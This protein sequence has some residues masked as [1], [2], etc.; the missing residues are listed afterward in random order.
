[1]HEGFLSD[2]IENPD[3]DTPRLVF[4][5]WL[6]ENGDPER[7]GFIRVQVELEKLP[8]GDPRRE[9]LERDER[10]LLQGHGTAWVRGI[11]PMLLREEAV[12][13][14][15]RGRPMW[16]FHRGFIEEVALD[17]DTFP[18]HAQALFARWPVRDAWMPYTN[19]A[20]HATL[21]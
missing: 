6:E 20:N 1:M 4:A 10:D 9:L 21:A 17:A 3:D 11:L 8:E 5:D 16:R 15:D 13:V 7:A 18:A 2:I 14:H 19:D 12:R